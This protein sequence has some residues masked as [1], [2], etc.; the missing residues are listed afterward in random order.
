MFEM[1]RNN[2]EGEIYTDQIQK[3][4]Y[5]TDASV[6][7]EM[8]VAVVRPKTIDDIKKIISFASENKLSIIPRTAGT[9]L[10][11]QV[12]G[13]GIIVDVSKYMTEIIELN[14]DEK[15]V[16]VQPG[17]V[18]DELNMYLEPYGLFFGPETSTS[19]RCM[20][21]GLVGNN[22]CGSHSILYGSTRDHTL[23]INA[24]LSDG[25]EVVFKP[26][27]S[28]EFEK[29]CLGNS[30]ENNIYKNIKEILSETT[31]Q[32]T[33]RKEYPRP[34][35]NRRNN[36]YAID[37]LLE[38]NVFSKVNESFNFCKLLAGSEGTLAFST[39]IKLNLV[40]LPPK[41]KAVIPVHL[42]KLNNAFKANLIALKYNPGAVEMLDDKILE[43]TKENIEQSKN[44]FFIKGDPE[45]LLVVEFAR[46]T[47]K[48]IEEIAKNLEKDMRAAGYGYHFPTLYN[49]DVN[50]VW[51][52]RKAGLGLLSNFPGLK[53]AEAF[54]EDTS[55]MPEDLPEYMEKYQEILKK[56]DLDCVY[57]AHIGSGELHLRP[58]LNLKEKEDVKIFRQVGTEVA[59]LVK[60]F[61]GSMSG[62][63]GDGRV[64][65][66]FIPII[67][68]EHNLELCK[69][70]K[71]SWDPNN[72]FNPNKIINTPQMN[73]SLR[74]EIGSKLKDIKTI[75]DFSNTLGI[76]GA[77]EKCNGSADCLKSP[78]IGGTMCPSYMATRDEKNST[79]A[80]ANILRE[81]LTRSTK[82]NPFNHKEIYEVMDQC[83]SCKACKSECPSTVDVAKLKAEFL[84]HYY[85]S[86]GVPLRSLLVANI[87]KVN[88]LGS[89]VPPVFN[90]FM[91]SKLIAGMIG[92]TGKRSMPLLDKITF[93]RWMKKNKKEFE[94]DNYPNGKVYLFNDEFTNFNDTDIGIKAIRLLT[95][96]GYEVVIPKHLESG[97]T[98]LSKGLI[99]SAK[100]IANK[101]IEY[102]KDIINDD[103]PL[104]GIE[105][106]AI[107]AFRDEYPDLAIK[108]LKP[109]AD[110]LAKSC[111]LFE[112]FLTREIANGKI[113][114]E[115][116]D[117][118][119]RKIKVHGH[120]QQKAIA[121]TKELVEILSFPKN[122]EVV[123]IASG[124]CG[125]AGA[126]G[127]E[128]EHYELSMKIGELVLFP[129]VRK[130]SD[131]TI[132][133]APGTSCRH[134]IKD[135]TGKD[136]YHPVEILYDALV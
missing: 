114:L 57:Y 113:K 125:M 41:I 42:N 116:F 51:A 101:N 124:C 121:S 38:S 81:Y 70:V 134:Q 26:L 77:S 127:Y 87:S 131:D 45:A 94:K 65:G 99:R 93:K 10:G 54:I 136:A 1:L 61:R 52:L 48:E 133:S 5:S 107:L 115:N 37:L 53:K 27:T 11:G 100:K 97:R 68:G 95:K 29:K 25:S 105:P 80:R 28:E 64:R 30:L 2:F 126:F 7:R 43:C 49:E 46:E 120:C 22:S 8:P 35:M 56:Y 15:W 106:S 90:F 102:M 92:F 3:I 67:I 9:S 23:E 117:E 18:L 50:K 20:I 19:S 17:V 98:Y 47:K 112:E 108:E 59:Q 96:L 32:N 55:V 66:E 72:I 104:V 128:K 79:R 103:S 129:E 14:V 91:K 73:T 74:Y 60:T 58:M 63:H 21:G 16:K 76:Q 24:I 119:P 82:K 13:K 6:Y 85:D 86:N 135:G 109:A 33:I 62:E 31:N 36:G 83:L 75:F 110:T 71:Q 34:E 130:A 12:V 89:L 111:F 40:P 122:H 39:E 4:L 44:R 123:E 88:A 78:L 118:K 84:Q 132:I 69:K